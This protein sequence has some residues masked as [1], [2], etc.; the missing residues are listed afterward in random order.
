MVTPSLRN[1]MSQKSL[2]LFTC[3]ISQGPSEVGDEST[4]ADEHAI[5]CCCCG[6]IRV[7]ALCN[8]GSIFVL[9]GAACIL[10][11]E[12]DLLDWSDLFPWSSSSAIMSSSP[13]LLLDLTTSE[14]STGECVSW[15]KISSCPT[16]IPLSQMEHEMVVVLVT[17]RHT[18]ETTKVSSVVALTDSSRVLF[19]QLVGGPQTGQ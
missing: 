13:L 16:I 10:T 6:C 4:A 5:F 12:A 1:T 8:V 19:F 18:L 17:L 15:I 7:K 3:C 14:C 2:N 9:W 11:G